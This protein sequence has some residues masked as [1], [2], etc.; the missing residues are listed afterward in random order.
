MSSS[1]PCGHDH[2]ED[3]A[4]RARRVRQ[5]IASVRSVF[6]ITLVL[7]AV[8]AISKAGYS[9]FA[10]SIALGA[11]SLHSILD[12]SSNVLA[13][14]GL[15]WSATPANSKHP[16]GLRKIEILVALGI[17]VL[18][19]IGLFEFAQAAV[20]SLIGGAATPPRIGWSGF[21]LVLATMVVNFFV[22]RYEHRKAHELHSHLLHADAQ[23]TQ[24]DLFA[25]AAVV[26]SFVAIRAGFG[27][28][29][30]VCALVL[31]ALVGRVAWLV[32]RQN[33][34]VLLDAAVL[35][36]AAVVELGQGVPGI[37]SIH[38]IRSRGIHSAVELDLHMEVAAE[39][40]VAAAHDLAVQ[41]ERDLKVRFPQVTD[42]VIHV[43]PLI[44]SESASSSSSHGHVPGPHSSPHSD[45]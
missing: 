23:H 28:A 29:D 6:L 9:Y 4:A 34:P 38:S 13:L 35:D 1:D 43:E 18:I 42:V 39:M 30:S 11:D 19:V 15:H 31:V 16:Y 36:P 10:G 26:V 7:N 33:V 40:S 44:E 2:G 17:G 41:I 14:I 22:T 45:S 5:H 27:W 20:K 21:A 3:E 12:A 32:F 37:Q 8:V 25:S 24:S